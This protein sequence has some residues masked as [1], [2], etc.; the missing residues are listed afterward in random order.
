MDDVDPNGGPDTACQQNF[1]NQADSGKVVE[2]ETEIFP[3][4]YK[5]EF[6]IDYGES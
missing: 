1:E 6:Y 5:K 2:E 3:G 4:I